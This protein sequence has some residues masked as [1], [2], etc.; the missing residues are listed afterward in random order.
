MIQAQG[1]GTRGRSPWRIFGWGMA[2][3]V[4]LLPLVGM[5]FTSEV[6]WTGFDFLVAGVMVGGVS[7][8]GAAA[9]AG[10]VAFNRGGTSTAPTSRSTV[11]I[12]SSRCAGLE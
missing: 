7:E 5:Q 6:N 2:A 8:G 9:K 1:I 12:M 3:V 11:G 10:L 4:L